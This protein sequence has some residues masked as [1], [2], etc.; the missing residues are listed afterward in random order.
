MVQNFKRK[1][2]LQLINDDYSFVFSK[3]RKKKPS[4]LYGRGLI[5]LDS[6]I[7]YEFQSARMCNIEQ[8]KEFTKSF[9]AKL[10]K[11]NKVIAPSIPVVPNYKYNECI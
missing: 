1:I 5:T 3:A 11:K 2:A 10:K 6:D 9:I 4:S 7:V 8:I